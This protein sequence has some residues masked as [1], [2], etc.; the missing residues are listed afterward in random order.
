[1]ATIWITLPRLRIYFIITPAR[2]RW[3]PSLIST[4]LHS[5]PRRNFE[6][7]QYGQDDQRESEQRDVLDQHKGADSQAAKDLEG[8]H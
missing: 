4:V 1:M 6:E 3:F 5:N 2:G 7:R 8:Q